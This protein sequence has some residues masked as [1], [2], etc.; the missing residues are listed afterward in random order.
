MARSS[1]WC[2]SVPGSQDA[3]QTWEAKYSKTLCGVLIPRILRS[4]LHARRPGSAQLTAQEG[5][6]KW[7]AAAAVR[8]AQ[9]LPSVACVGGEARQ[10]PDPART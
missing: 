4:Y 1:S 10:P 8:H 2:H 9:G 3:S 7:G 6:I 5:Q